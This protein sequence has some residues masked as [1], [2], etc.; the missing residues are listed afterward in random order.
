MKRG[1]KL[2]LFM[3]AVNLLLPGYGLTAEPAKAPA[4][5]ETKVDAQ[6]PKKESPAANSNIT[7]ENLEFDFGSIEQGEKVTHI[8]NF[9]NTGKDPLV[10]DKVQSSCGC[11]AAIL[12]SKTILPGESG[13]IETTFNSSRFHGRINKTITVNSN[14]PDEPVVR[15]QLTGKVTSELMIIPP[16]ELF[17]GLIEYKKPAAKSF[18]LTQGEE[19]PL[20]VSKAECDLTF[21]TTE[22]VPGTQGNK[23]TYQ[24]MLTVNDKAPLGRFEGTV[25]IYTNL[26]KYAVIERKVMG[27]VKELDNAAAS[28]AAP[29]QGVKESLL[30]TNV[31]PINKPAGQ[32]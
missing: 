15:L 30:P 25:K 13:S 18:L 7:F 16:D 14:D 21:V 3:I 19:T 29:E 28:A 12:S 8:F 6:P 31:A 32:K 9:K 5:A 10:I 1:Q 17:F 24:V 4:A 26:P 22:I 20:E 11:T 27:I 23:K 2:V